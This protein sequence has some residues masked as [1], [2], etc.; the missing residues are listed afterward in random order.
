MSLSKRKASQSVA[1]SVKSKEEIDR[2]TTSLDIEQYIDY[3]NY[4]QLQEIL[5]NHLRHIQ[6]HNC[7]F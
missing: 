3:Q 7:L 2:F 4:L 5:I 6:N 1:R